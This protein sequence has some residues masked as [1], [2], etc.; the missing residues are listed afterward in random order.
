MSKDH[1]CVFCAPDKGRRLITE[2]ATAYAIY[3]KYPVSEGHALIIPKRH[4]A[5]Y[6]DLMEKEQQACWLVVNHVKKLLAEKY[7]TQSFNIGINIGE[8]AG[9]TIP[10]AHIHLIPRYPGDVSKPEGGVRH[11]IP[12]KG[13][14]IRDTND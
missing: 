6:F 2:S 1:S 10:H 8:V 5:N 13:Y 7:G 12:A 14:Y 9:Q 3:D 4:V 11:V